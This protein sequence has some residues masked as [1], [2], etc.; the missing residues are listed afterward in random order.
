MSVLRRPRFDRLFAPAK[1]LVLAS[2]LID[3]GAACAMLALQFRGKELGASP[4]VLGFLGTAIFVIYVPISLLSGH[5]SD[6][7][8]RRCITIIASAICMVAW[9]GMAASTS[10]VQLLV[11]ALAYGSGLG[12][13]WPP[14]EAWLADLSGGSARLLNRHLGLFNI[15]WTG[16]LM[17]GPLVAGIAWE[18][19]NVATFGAAGGVALVCLLIAVFTP[20]A[21]P[22][23]THIAPPSHV[24]TSRVWAFL[25]VSWCGVLGL[26]FCRGLI[27]TAFPNLA[28]TIGYSERLIGFL[29]FV[30]AGG[31]GL[32]FFITRLTTGWQ[33]RLWPLGVSMVTVI[34]AMVLSGLTGNPWVF[35]ATFTVIGAAL[36]VVYMAGITY[37]MM[38]EPERRGQRAGLHEAIM[39]TGLVTGPF[40]G[41][42][43]A[44]YINLQAPFLVGAVVV[45][46]SLLAQI[47]VWVR[48][49]PRAGRA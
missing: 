12:L 39:G 17:A 45:L 16:G 41:G 6:R 14:V 31:Q 10:I 49:Q 8:G 40:L 47:M 13:L 5:L 22:A 20:T 21:P 19:W 27:G 37:A 38:S 46:L 25:L 24:D 29:V 23:D 2:F 15:A 43:A 42:F 1:R 18:S 7:W 35:A 26:S 33:F 3:V 48:L 30:L 34:G 36:G 28:K 32:T 9:F 11:L 4:L 44:Q